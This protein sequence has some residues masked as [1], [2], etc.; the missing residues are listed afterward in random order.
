MSTF[1]EEV[2]RKVGQWVSYAD[3]DLKLATYALNMDE[4][5][6]YKLVAYHA[7]QCA[8]K[9]LKSFLV[10]RGVDF[11]YTHNIARLLELCNDA[12]AGTEE[13]QDAEELTPYA[14]TTRYPGEDEEVSL[15][16]ASLAIDTAVH[17]RKVIRRSLRAFGLDDLPGD[18]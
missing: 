14:I 13:L 1:T 11:P 3:E 16:E 5:C 4:E 15:D 6:P 8:E 7:Q 18:E 17:V 9:Y 10:M 2:A 12:G